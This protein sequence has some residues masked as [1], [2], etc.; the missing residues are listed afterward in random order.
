[1]QVWMK[2]IIG[3]ILGILIGY[4]FGAN[5]P[6]EYFHGE[7]G[8]T[9]I[10]FFNIVGE[11]FLKLLKMIVVPLIFFSLCIGIASMEDI[12]EVGTAGVK[13]LAYFMTTTAI[14]ICIGVILSSV[15][16]PGSFV[17]TDKRDSI[18]QQNQTNAEK[19][20]KSARAQTGNEKA[21]KEEL[22]S[23]RGIIGA[24]KKGAR[25]LKKNLLEM[26]PANPI[27]AMADTRILQII[28]FAIF[29]G[30]G[31][32]QLKPD[33]KQF[34]LQ[35]CNIINDIMVFLVQMIMA[36]APYGVCTLMA[37]SVSKVGLSVMAAL[38]VYALTVIGGLLLHLLLVYM[39]VASFSSGRSPLN[40]LMQIK[41][42]LILAFSTSSSSATLPVTMKCVEENLKVPSKTSSFVLPL[43]ATVNMD[44]TALYQ[45]VAVVFIAQVFGYSLSTGDLVSIVLMATL[46][47]VGA[48]GVPGAGM[49]TLVMVLDT[50]NPELVAGVALVMGVDRFLDMVR[51]AVNVT[52]DSTA[53]CLM[54]WLNRGPESREAAKS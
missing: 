5:S 4:L 43:G 32:T 6:F 27:E 38:A 23:E 46:A 15:I 11:V 14:A 39:P 40:F 24:F 3:M 7:L 33:H 44:G 37:Y 16:K 36:I 18:M 22:E 19:Y 53:C 47:S 25:L 49:I 26:I 29:F 17:N 51:T 10:G 52:G 2:I 31:I 30:I 21:S 8:T 34:I 45:G 9:L 28:V 50:V 35:F 54:D 48:A 1:M 42:A 41:E 20:K 13:L 12:S